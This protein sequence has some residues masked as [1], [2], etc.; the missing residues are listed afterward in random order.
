M[1]R[2]ERPPDKPS[3]RQRIRGRAQRMSER[4]APPDETTGREPMSWKH[5][6]GIASLCVAA[7]VVWGAILIWTVN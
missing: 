3:L 2:T 1:T 5:K 4:M 6:A 7:L